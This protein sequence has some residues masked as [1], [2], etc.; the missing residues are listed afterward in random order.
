MSSFFAQVFDVFVVLLGDPFSAKTWQVIFQFIRFVL[1][2]EVPVYLLVTLG[3]LKYGLIRMSEKY[4]QDRNFPSVSCII[5]CYS[6]GEGVKRTIQT[7]AE[8][9]YPGLIQIIAVIDGAAQ[10]QKTYEAAK[11]MENVVSRIPKRSLLVLPKWKRGGRVSSLNA[12]LA[13]A[14]GDIVMALDGDTSF[15]NNM[16][17]RATR[18][19]EDPDVACVA[20]SLKVRNIRKSLV[21]RLQAIEYFLSI[22]ASRTGLSAFNMVNN[23]SGA[24]GV[25]RKDVLKTVMGWSTGSAEDLDLTLRVKNYFGR[26][27]NMKIVFDPE[28]VGLTDVPETFRDFFRQRLRWDG[29]L[30]YIYFRKHWMSFNPRLVGWKNF[31]A[32]LWTGLLFQIVMPFAITGYLTYLAV[33]FPVSFALGI[34]ALV[35]LF[36]LSVTAFFFIIFVL[37][38]SER[39]WQDMK[40]FPWIVFMPLF[41][42]IN[43]V[44]NAF[45]T[46]WEIFGKAHQDTSMAPWWVIK[47]REKTDET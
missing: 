25:F 44:H 12:G 41:S 31:I 45:S 8:Q 18:H 21:T 20:G 46:L 7:L 1:F 26:Y 38:L 30:S 42:M 11:S 2:F 19:F 22:Q 16:V 33:A 28:A 37:V 43:R 6:E 27:K 34:M 9:F 32:L 13:V 17:E 47:R 3:I 4:T 10:N 29:D 14:R 24:F 40:L 23:I 36:Y 5:T 15:D 35:Y 39:P